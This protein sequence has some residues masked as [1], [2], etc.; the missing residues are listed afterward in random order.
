LI[1]GHPR[2]RLKNPDLKD[3]DPRVKPGGGE[4]FCRFNLM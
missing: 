2:L 3:V 4:C 1:R